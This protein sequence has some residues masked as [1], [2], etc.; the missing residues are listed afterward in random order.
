[1]LYHNILKR[2]CDLLLEQMPANLERT[3]PLNSSEKQAKL[4][5]TFQYILLFSKSVA[6]RTPEPTVGL[7][8]HA[9][10]RVDACP[11][12]VGLL[13]SK[14]QDVLQ[15]IQ[16]HLNNLGVHDSKEVTER[17]DATQVDQ[18]SRRDD[19][20]HTFAFQDSKHHNCSVIKDKW[21]KL[22]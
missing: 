9:T 19:Q 17:L 13:L 11:A 8:Y 21:F 15:A 18:V 3:Q 2:Q 22:K 16:C 7:F 12:L 5:D 14:P 6:L 10:V 1:M 4:V 20:E